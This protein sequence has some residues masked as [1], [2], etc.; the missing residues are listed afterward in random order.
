MRLLCLDKTMLS[1]EQAFCDRKFFNLLFVVEL[2][3]Q[4]KKESYAM[5][6]WWLEK[7]R[8]EASTIVKNSL[9]LGLFE[10][11]KGN[12]QRYENLF[13]HWTEVRRPKV[14]LHDDGSNSEFRKDRNDYNHVS[15][16]LFKD[17]APKETENS[18]NTLKEIGNM[19]YYLDNHQIINGLSSPSTIATWILEDIRLFHHS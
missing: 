5:E 1:I 11:I 4:D 2:G 7:N 14:Q 6:R 9:Y 12:K 13:E 17:N 3:D 10:T 16:K 8:N 19:M 15:Q 18:T